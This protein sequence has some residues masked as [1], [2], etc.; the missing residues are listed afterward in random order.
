M[1]EGE[2]SKKIKLENLNAK[3]LILALC[4]MKNSVG[5]NSVRDENRKLYP[6]NSLYMMTEGYIPQASDNI[7]V[8]SSGGYSLRNF[9]VTDFLRVHTRSSWEAM[10]ISKG[11]LSSTVII[12][13]HGN[14]S[15]PYMTMNGLIIDPTSPEFVARLR[16]IRL[17]SPSAMFPALEQIKLAYNE[18]F[19]DDNLTFRNKGPFPILDKV[20]SIQIRLQNLLFQDLPVIDAE[21]KTTCTT[22]VRS[23]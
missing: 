13:Q 9:G 7:S 12:D 2:I 8:E 17:F 3:E 22:V 14:E 20:Q 10:G 23:H 5:I 4:K 18:H 15:Y 19:D 1:K 11:K 16:Q 21:I 6:V